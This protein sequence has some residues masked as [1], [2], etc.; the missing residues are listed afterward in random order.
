[1]VRQLLRALYEAI[2][3][4]ALESV[5]KASRRRFRRPTQERTIRRGRI[6]Y[7]RVERW[8][9]RDFFCL[10]SITLATVGYDELPPRP[11]LASS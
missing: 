2:T 7:C 4:Q 5:Y 3:P 9:L 10:N 1:L 8:N 11:P 6:L